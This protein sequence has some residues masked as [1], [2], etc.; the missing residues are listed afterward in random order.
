MSDIV[1]LWKYKKI[2]RIHY[3]LCQKWFLHSSDREVGTLITLSSVALRQ[4]IL[5]V[6]SDYSW[7]I[8]VF[9][10]LSP[11]LSVTILEY[12]FFLRNKRLPE[13]L[14]C[15]SELFL[16]RYSPFMPF[17]LQN[18]INGSR[19]NLAVYLKPFKFLISS[20]QPLIMFKSSNGFFVQS[21]SLWSPNFQRSSHAQN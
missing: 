15:F 20:C 21:F 10:T 8:L 14:I 2:S 13:F 4:V 19:K 18:S 16:L 17:Q 3:I 12:L 6:I 1:N 7:F 5:L 11:E 9:K